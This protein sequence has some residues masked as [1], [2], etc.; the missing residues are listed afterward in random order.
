MDSNIFN[1]PSSSKSRSASATVRGSAVVPRLVTK[2]GVEEEPVAA[3]E[4]P[5]HERSPL[6]RITQVCL[7]PASMATAVRGLAVVP[8]LFVSVGEE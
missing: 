7:H 8:K 3:F 2:F 4:L 5:Q 6:S 1:I